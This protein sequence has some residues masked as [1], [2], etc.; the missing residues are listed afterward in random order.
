MSGVF[1]LV[2]HG[3][4]MLRGKG[5][6]FADRVDART[7]L[8]IKEYEHLYRRVGEFEYGNKKQQVQPRNK[9]SLIRANKKTK[10]EMNY[11]GIVTD[12]AGRKRRILE[13]GKQQDMYRDEKKHIK[14]QERK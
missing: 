13:W 10:Q 7:V 6:D 9:K 14:K 3:T 5:M 2:P 1:V 4:R 12:K 8:L 11:L